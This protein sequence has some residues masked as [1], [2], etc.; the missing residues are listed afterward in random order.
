MIRSLRAQ[1]FMRY[2][3]LE[4]LDL[5]RGAIAIEGDNEA[6]KTTIGECRRLRALRPDG[7]DRGDRSRRRRSTGTPIAP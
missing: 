1:S 4:L 6:G 2:E 3:S 7:A 5:P